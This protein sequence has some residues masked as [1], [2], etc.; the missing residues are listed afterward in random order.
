MFSSHNK[1][2]ASNPDFFISSEG[3]TNAYDE[4]LATIEAMSQPFSGDDHAMC[5][6]PARYTW[7]VNNDAL[8]PMDISLC[9][10]LNQF[11]HHG[12]VKS[13]SLMFASGYLGN[14]ASMYGHLLLKMNLEE[15][16]A[17]ELLD[18]TLNYGAQ[19]PDNEG[20]LAYIALGILG[21][22]EARYSSGQFYRHSHIYN[23]TELRDLYEYRLTLT[24]SDVELILH[25]LWELNQTS[26]TYYFFRQNCGYYFAHLLSLVSQDEILTAKPWVLP[27]DVIESFNSGVLDFEFVKRHPSR[28][29]VFQSK[30]HQLDMR[31]QAAVVELVTQSTSTRFSQ[32]EDVEQK[33]VIDVALDYVAFIDTGD[34]E[35]IRQDLLVKRFQLSA[36]Q[37]EWDEKPVF[38]PHQGQK[39]SLLSLTPLW[40]ES[41]DNALNLRFR[42]SNFDLLNQ[43]PSAI[44]G[45]QLVMGDVSLDFYSDRVRL[46]H[47]TVFDIKQYAAPSTGLP[48]DNDF[49]WHVGLGVEKEAVNSEKSI[50]KFHGGYG[51]STRLSDSKILYG[52][53]TAAVQYPSRSV[54]YLALGGRAGFLWQGDTVSMNVEIDVFNDVLDDRAWDYKVLSELRVA[55]DRD[56]EVRLKVKHDQSA[57]VGMSFNL[58]F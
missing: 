33:R 26:F 40:R 37:V 6:F 13:L 22:Y 15:Q 48:G 54:S 56:R 32:L 17:S 29:N 43:S 7:L 20:A 44:V 36:G 53:A 41:E 14:P 35:L 42:I 2:E 10:S 39:P 46:N 23:E 30:F 45:N 50:A 1:S 16:S 24:D 52:L 4:L 5:R 8:S 9:E 25:H 31:E 12:S 3:K 21:G 55:L 58:Y 19:V 51:V 57:E 49:A 27:I 47:F 11:K 28:Q 38:Y 34:S 18:S